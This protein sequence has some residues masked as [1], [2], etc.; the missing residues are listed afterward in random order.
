MAN[1]ASVGGYIKFIFK[2]KEIKW[3][4]ES[5]REE[6]GQREREKRGKD[7]KRRKRETE[8]KREKVWKKRWNS[9]CIQFMSWQVLICNSQ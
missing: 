5:E 4:K 9:L 7:K 3:E 6:Y 2:K 1:S 8:R